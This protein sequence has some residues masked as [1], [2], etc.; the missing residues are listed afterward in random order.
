MEVHLSVFT[1]DK[2]GEVMDRDQPILI[3]AE[4][5]IVDVDSY[6]MM[7]VQGSSVRYACH[8]DCWNG[9]EEPV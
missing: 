8:L 6:E 9:I 5:I 1:C 2:C 4:G 3:I 7:A